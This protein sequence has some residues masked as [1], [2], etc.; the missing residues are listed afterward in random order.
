VNNVNN[1]K[2]MN[3]S[4]SPDMLP[5]AAIQ[6]V[7]DTDVATN[8]RS[9][10]DLVLQAAAQGAKLVCLPEYFCL[11]GKKDTDK[12]LIMEQPGNGPIQTFL[13]E[14]SV[15]AGV[16]L[17]A[18]TVP[19]R[20]H[21]RTKV[22]NSLL[23]LNP[24]GQQVARYDK[25]H[26]FGLQHGQQVFNESATIEPGSTPVVVDIDG[27]RVGL[28]ICYD[29]RFPELYRAMGRCDLMV[30]PSAFTY[31][32][33]QAHWE[34]LLRARAIENQCYVLASAQGGEHANGRTT[35]GHSMLIDPWGTIE[36]QV[37]S[38]PAVVM[39]QVVR[40]RLKEVRAMLPAL[41][42]RKLG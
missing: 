2:R 27:W 4:T 24:Q 18:G 30:V 32:T 15:Q 38:G 12:L 3:Q 10:K 22:R 28:S 25:V 8:L 7:S 19:L 21:H 37:P 42:H 13:Q 11:L 34:L 20:G 40:Q 31:V 14:L 6:M 16:W 36:Q 39:G 41:A 17:L 35:W 26:L 23:V 5:V 1:P 33:G 9:A 29:L